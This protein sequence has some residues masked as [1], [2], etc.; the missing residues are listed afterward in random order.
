VCP[1]R[2][3]SGPT[4]V[5]PLSL[6]VAPSTQIADERSALKK[7]MALE[8]GERQLLD[9]LKAEE[10]LSAE[11]EVY[12]ALAAV[13]QTEALQRTAQ[14]TAVCPPKTAAAKPPSK[15]DPDELR[16]E[17]AE[18]AADAMLRQMQDEDEAAAKD[19]QEYELVETPAPDEEGDDN[20]EAHYT[21][22]PREKGVVKFNFTPRIFPTPMRESKQGEEEDWVAKN[23]T[24]LR[25]NPTLRPQLDA[26]DIEDGDPTWLK[27]KGDDFYRARDYRAA[28]NAYTTALEL[29][30]G[31]VPVQ[32]IERVCVCAAAH[33]L[34]SRVCVCLSLS[35]GC[36]CVFTGGGLGRV[37]GF[38]CRC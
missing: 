19:A 25:K 10:K 2:S 18:A 30:S 31:L 9:D 37:R 32:K 24:H 23:R 12:K 4:S 6:G 5:S 13:E 36:S 15:A 14:R 26:M 22:Q 8:E 21:P 27:G 1:E 35:H 20:L 28:V 11:E 16:E 29:D 34:C 7:Q 3:S 33:F 17:T 38:C